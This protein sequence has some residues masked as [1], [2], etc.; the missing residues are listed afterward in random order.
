MFHRHLIL[1]LSGLW[2]APYSSVAEVGK[3]AAAKYFKARE[4][5]KPAA[6]TATPVKTESTSSTE[7]SSASDGPRYMALHIGSFISDSAY[8]WGQNRRQHNV[9][10]LTLGVSYRMGEWVNSMDVWLRADVMAYSLKQGRA[11]RIAFLPVLTF[12]DV[13]SHFPLYFGAGAGAG[14]FFKEVK[15]ESNFTFDYQLFTGLRMLNALSNMGVFVEG[16]LKN[17]ILLTSDGQF[18]G[19]YLALGAVFNF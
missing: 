9:G 18:N 2:L 16:G 15:N 10:Q 7:V 5:R 17:F 14:V 3:G 4:P 11:S 8:R 12:P 1:L 6:E 19:Y 13:S